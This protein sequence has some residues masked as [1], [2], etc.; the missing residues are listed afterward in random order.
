MTPEDRSP[1]Q[2]PEQAEAKA[3]E[4]VSPAQGAAEN[5]SA[6]PGPAGEPDPDASASDLT[7]EQLLAEAGD[8]SEASAALAT[9]QQLAEERLADL[10]RLQAE[11]VN[12]RK[13]VDRDR[14]VAGA[15]GT[16]KVIEALLPV[17]D[18]VVLAR[19]HGD[20]TE[21][22]AASIADKLDGVLS[23]FGLERY[24]EAGEPFDPTVHEAL[25]H[26]HAEGIEVT[27]VTQVLQP[28]YKVGGRVL[29][30]ARVAVADPQ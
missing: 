4:A 11:Y 5:T 16:T 14:D 19:S 26:G 29:R 7:P 6:A 30:A 10:Q 15:A 27:T 1:E 17:L 13:R 21:G 20:L 28:G 23:R 18:D 25:M 12:Y 3:D 2:T 24:G 8:A 9:A 22:P